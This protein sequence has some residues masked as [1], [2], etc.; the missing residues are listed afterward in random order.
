[1]IATR[2]LRR[3]RVLIVG[4]GDVGLRCAAQLRARR[5]APKILA[6]T[7]HAERRAEL[8]ARGV[9]PLI[10]DLDRRATLRRLAGLAGSVLHLAPPAPRGDDDRR[11]GALLAA[12]KTPRARALRTPGY[13]RLRHLAAEY[14]AGS[15][16]AA[17]PV[18][19]RGRR[20]RAAIVPAPVLPRE[21]PVVVYA[22]T[23]GVYGDCAG[24]WID[25]TRPRRPASARARRRVAAERRLRA[26]TARGAVSARL[27][28]IP[29]IYAEDRL[30]LER[31]RKGTPAL[32]AADDVYT[33]HIHADDLARILLR[34]GERGRPARAY[35]ASDDSELKMGEYFARVARAFALPEPPRIARAEAERVLDPVLLSFMSESRRMRNARIKREL[36]VRLRFPRVDDTLRLVG[37][38]QRRQRLDQNKAE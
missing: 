26:A 10:G 24:D 28:R 18:A 11:T 2:I 12:L 37:S 34:A 33:N 21:A 23:S 13:G 16:A 9:V 15:G 8:R 6:L 32:R 20:L 38:D 19:A 31:L 27:V 3:P 5:A 35:H 29:G 25:E 36:G 30:P 14:R 7:S 17:A 4:C 1:M 22:S